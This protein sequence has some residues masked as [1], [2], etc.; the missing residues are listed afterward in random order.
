MEF[1]QP[2]GFPRDS[3]SYSKMAS[4]KG[5][6]RW[7]KMK[8]S[9]LD[10]EVSFSTENLKNPWILYESNTHKV[11]KWFENLSTQASLCYLSVPDSWISINIFYPKYCLKKLPGSLSS[12]ILHPPIKPS[13]KNA[14]PSQKVTP[15]ALMDTAG[16]PRASTACHQALGMKMASP[17]ICVP[18][19]RWKWPPIQ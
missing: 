16:P 14:M 11:W 18:K 1:P 7:R 2:Q 4:Q 8:V 5:L 9:Q 17:A 19:C 12:K 10:V 13:I 15:R 6:K 3:P